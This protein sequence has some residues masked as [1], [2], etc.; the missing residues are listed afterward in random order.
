MTRDAQVAGAET[1]E[2][3]DSSA[4]DDLEALQTLALAAAEW[5]DGVDN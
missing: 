1:N 4:V 2:M 3:I 5:H